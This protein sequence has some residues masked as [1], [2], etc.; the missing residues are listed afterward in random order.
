[1]SSAYGIVGR[2]AGA[3]MLELVSK[4]SLP[5]LAPHM[6][7]ACTRQTRRG[8]A[9]AARR[10]YARVQPSDDSYCEWHCRATT[11]LKDFVLC[12]YN[13]EAR[14]AM[15][16]KPASRGTGR[17]ASEHEWRGHGLPLAS[18]DWRSS[19]LNCRV[20]TRRR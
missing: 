4:G 6:E 17:T 16:A 15:H 10:M 2:E 5:S 14:L 7:L 19:A 8:A 13:R 20:G 11:A 3:R 1:M 18:I 9:E 12:T